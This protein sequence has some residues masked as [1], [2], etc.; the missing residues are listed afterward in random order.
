MEKKNKKKGGKN[1][2]LYWLAGAAGAV[3]LVAS[4]V[5]IIG[6]FGGLK[7]EQWSYYGVTVV[8]SFSS[9]L[10]TLFFGIS[11]YKHNASMREINNELRR[12][13]NSV[14]RR[15]EAFRNL[16][17]VASNYTIVDFVDCITIYPEYENYLIKLRDTKAFDFYLL[18]Q[19]VRKEDV[20]EKFGNYMYLSVRIPFKIAEGKTIGKL[21]FKRFKFTKAADSHRFAPASDGL[22]KALLL[23]NESAK[24]QEA[25]INLVMS[26]DSKFY[27]LNE[28]NQFEKIKIDLEMESLLGVIVRGSIELYFTNPEK[29]EKTGASKYRINSSQFEL[30]GTPK[31]AASK[32]YEID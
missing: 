27:S 13:T 9:F 32:E 5:V 17:F 20:I 12:Q 22:G 7:F 26:K 29:L 21:T 19:G 30:V 28:L 24:R 6:A 3:L 18:E 31:L 8:V 16:Q 2:V 23:Y 14:N 11:I 25:V 15:A 10:A 4:T 1:V